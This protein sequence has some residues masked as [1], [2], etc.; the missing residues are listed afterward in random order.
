MNLGSITQNDLS[1]LI[2]EVSEKK[3]IC[4]A[5]LILYVMFQIRALMCALRTV[6]LRVA[7]IL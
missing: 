4:F 6:T 3:F 7:T 1:K 5:N 2:K